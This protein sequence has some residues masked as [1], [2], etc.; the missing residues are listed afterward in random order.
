MARKS[1]IAAAA[2]ASL[3]VPFVPAAASACV[4]RSDNF[5][6]N[7]EWHRLQ[8]RENSTPRIDRSALDS[9]ALVSEKMS[10]AETGLKMANND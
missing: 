10:P 4:W 3:A 6:E 1:I 7:W 5:K 9:P 8:S 2:L